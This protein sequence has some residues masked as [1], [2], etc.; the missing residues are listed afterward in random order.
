MKKAQTA[1]RKRLTTS[2]TALKRQNLSEKEIP[3]PYS[4]KK[5]GNQNITRYQKCANPV[6]RALYGQTMELKQTLSTYQ[7]IIRNLAVALK[8][9]VK[10]TA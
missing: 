9:S 6:H 5:K 8:I 7:D 2:I 10:K 1:R 3:P 4:A